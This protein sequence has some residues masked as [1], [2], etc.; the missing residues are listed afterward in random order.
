VGAARRATDGPAGSGAATEIVVQ[1]LREALPLVRDFIADVCL[2]HDV[3]RDACFALTV[4]ADEVCAN[5]VEHGYAGMPAGRI[6]VAVEL[7]AGEMRVI[8][9][10]QG[11]SFAPEEAPRPDLGLGWRERPV[12]GLG[13]HLVRSLVDGVDHRPGPAGGNVVTLTKRFDRRSGDPQEER[14]DGHQG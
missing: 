6:R 12:G 11:R 13:W 3:P 8:V 10:D 7:E 4:A 1:A 9:S 2:R 14:R 5:V